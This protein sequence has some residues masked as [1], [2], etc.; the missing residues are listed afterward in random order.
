MLCWRLF[1]QLWFPGY[2]LSF[3]QCAP[4]SCTHLK[5]Q[6]HNLR[7]H[8]AMHRLPIHVG[9]KVSG[10]EPRLLSW[11]PLL[12]MLETGHHKG[13]G[14][15]GSVTRKIPQLMC[16][17]LTSVC[18]VILI[19]PYEIVIILPSLQMKKLKLKGGMDTT[20]HRSFIQAAW[21]LSLS[22]PW[23]GFLSPHPRP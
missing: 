19:T 10:T 16:Q 8:H 13:A 3:P 4:P 17:A 14:L 2:P 21:L 22:C 12:H 18:T 23:A 20:G 9:D 7:M 15:T 6:L 1:R 5:D 11:A